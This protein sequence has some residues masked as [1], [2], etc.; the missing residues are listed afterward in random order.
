MLADNFEYEYLKNVNPFGTV[1]T[2]VISSER[3]LTDSRSILEYLD[4]SRSSN[5]NTSLTPPDM[6]G[7][8]LMNDLIEL[9][10]SSDASTNLLL[11]QARDVLEY[12]QKKRG[13][14]IPWIALRQAI[15]DTNCSAHPEHEFY[16]TKAKE[17]GMLHHIYT[18]PVGTE[19][20]EFIR[21]TQA[22]YRKFTAGMDRLESSLRLPY[23][24]GEDVS[25]ADLHI[26]PWLSHALLAVGTVDIPD[27][28][29]LEAQL[30][31]TVPEFKV[32]LKT[33][34]WWANVGKRDSFKQVFSKLR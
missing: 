21:A 34:E 7:K 14:F 24:V 2:L 23:A 6:E 11:L 25:Q 27:F 32:G 3:P 29:K 33:R 8:V 19:H 31:K 10:H 5:G 26:V 9:V 13:P 16:A 12:E 1:P 4:H 17:N 28:S 22:G 20:E 18:T 30:Q 15:L